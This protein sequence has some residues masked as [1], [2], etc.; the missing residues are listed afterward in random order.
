MYKISF[1]IGISPDY[2][3]NLS[4]DEFYDYLGIYNKKAISKKKEKIIM[5]NFLSNQIIQGVAGLF[6]EKVERMNIWDYF[7]ELFKEEKREYL[8]DKEDEE[9]ERFKARRKAFAMRIKK[10]MKG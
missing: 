4:I 6:D 3:W 7:P 5:L 10:K 1:E 8:K 9:F 2:F